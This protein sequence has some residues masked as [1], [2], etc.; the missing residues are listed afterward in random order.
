MLVSD[1][2]SE[3]KGRGGVG[4]QIGVIRAELVKNV[5]ILALG[6]P[7]YQVRVEERLERNRTSVY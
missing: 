4:L 2:G 6:A 7:A 5:I 1:L 3:G